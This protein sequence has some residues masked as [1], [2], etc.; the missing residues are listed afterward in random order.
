MT[1]AVDVT[2]PADNV[3]SSKADFRA[4]FLVIKDEISALQVRAGVAGA[5]AFYDYVER[6]DLE[7]IVRNQFLTFTNN[8]ARDIA[9][10]RV[11]LT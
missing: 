5:A 9:Y 1:S 3:K 4:Q 6:P 2:L 8:L 11:S 10:G 7:A